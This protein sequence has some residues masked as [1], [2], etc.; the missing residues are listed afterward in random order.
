MTRVHSLPDKWLPVSIASWPR[1][2]VAIPLIPTV[3]ALAVRL[4]GLSDKPLW[5]DEIITQRRANLP[6]SDL[7]ANSLDNK[8]FPTYFVFV[9]A[10][11]APIIDEWTLRLPSAIFGA[12]S[13]LLVVLI[14]TAARSRGAGLVAGLLMA[15]S[16]FEVQF[17]QE[18]R[19]YTLV[20][21]FILLALWGLV[22]IAQQPLIGASPSSRS[23]SIPPNLGRL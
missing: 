14:A 2:T 10:F 7:I 1:A 23:T 20:S 13:V 6:I 22:R 4:H 3:L 9:R 15:L 12:I 11:D 18:A 21:C 16:P 5:L 19:S 8:H 17:G